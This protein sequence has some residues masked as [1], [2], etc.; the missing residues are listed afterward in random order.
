MEVSFGPK[1]KF[2]AKFSL[3]WLGPV[4]G[5]LPVLGKI[6]THFEPGGP[7]KSEK[8]EKIVKKLKISDFGKSIQM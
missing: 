3:F 2:F 1:V 4:L 7:K 5:G 8:V 6:L